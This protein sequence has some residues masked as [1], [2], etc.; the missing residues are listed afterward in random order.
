MMNLNSGEL[1]LGDT[2]VFWLFLFPAGAAAIQKDLQL[3]GVN[4]PIGNRVAHKEGQH[5]KREAVWAP[6]PAVQPSSS[7]WVTNYF[8]IQDLIPAI[9]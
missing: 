2:D 6:S 8:N 3:A 4:I 5:D 7:S 1:P 9:L